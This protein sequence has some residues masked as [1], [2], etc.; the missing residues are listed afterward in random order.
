MEPFLS[1]IP[2][3]GSLLLAV[4]ALNIVLLLIIIMQSVR[5]SRVRKSIN[6]LMTGAGGANLEEG[7]HRLLDQLDQVMKQHSDQQFMIN[8]LAQR[9]AAQRGNVAV[10]RYNA[11]GDV[12]SDLSFSIAIL[13]DAQNGVV[14]TSIFGREESRV[15]AKPVE[16]GS[17][18]YS[19]SEE[20][21][22][23]IKK[24]MNPPVGA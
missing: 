20:E 22:A 10:I 3:A 8:R 24:A 4:I 2:N 1:Q 23:V 13:D 17:S 9:I 6:R 18:P 11:F 16:A 7:M 5:I 21:Q 19:L 15:Y 12:G 14:I